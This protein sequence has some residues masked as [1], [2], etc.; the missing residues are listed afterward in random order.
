MK[1]RLRYFASLREITGQSEETLTVP[2]Q[3]SVADMRTRLVEQYPRL[4]SLIERCIYAVN[5]SYVP[6]DT[7]LQDNDELV[8]IPPMGGGAQ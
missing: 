6:I 2:D 7:Q 8:F 1:I 4:Q 5:R 3:A